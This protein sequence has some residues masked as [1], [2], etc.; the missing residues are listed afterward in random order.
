MWLS[1][2][3]SVGATLDSE[4]RA[5]RLTLFLVLAATFVTSQARKWFPHIDRD[6]C[7]NSN[8]TPSETLQT[9]GMNSD[10]GI[11]ARGEGIPRVDRTCKCPKKLP[12]RKKRSCNKRASKKW[13]DR[14]GVVGV[15]F[16]NER[17]WSQTWQCWEWKKSA[18]PKQ[19]H[20][21]EARLPPKRAW[22]SVP[23]RAS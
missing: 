23:I 11:L 16:V 12:P 2:T 8:G 13:P 20:Q 17:G 22:E 18:A 6:V 7:T 21:T 9:T 5:L 3:Q 10:Y 19:G 4:K 1:S 14:F 15:C